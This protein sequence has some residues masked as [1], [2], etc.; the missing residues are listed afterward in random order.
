MSLYLII[1]LSVIV[2]AGFLCLI[3]G[4]GQTSKAQMV[5]NDWARALG[6]VMVAAIIALAAVAAV[7][8]MPL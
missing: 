1:A 5:S 6:W 2:F 3:S 7:D 4:I 8:R